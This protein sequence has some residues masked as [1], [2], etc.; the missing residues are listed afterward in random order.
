MLYVKLKLRY[1]VTLGAFGYFLDAPACSM[2]DVYMGR[3]LAEVRESLLKINLFRHECGFRLV[4]IIGD[5]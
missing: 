5:F 3:T 1:D 4:A 2:H